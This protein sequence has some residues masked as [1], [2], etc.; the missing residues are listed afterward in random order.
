MDFH[1]PREYDPTLIQ[2]HAERLNFRRSLGLDYCEELESLDDSH[3]TVP[4]ETYVELQA[5]HQRLSEQHAAYKLQQDSARQMER[6]ARTLVLSSLEQYKAQL[7]TLRAKDHLNM[8]LIASLQRQIEDLERKT[9]LKAAVEGALP[10]VNALELISKEVE[11]D[12]RLL[13]VR[14]TLQSAEIR[15]KEEAAEAKLLAEKL[16]KRLIEEKQRADKAVQAA[17]RAI[18]YAKQQTN[19]AVDPSTEP[20]S[21]QMPSKPAKIAPSASKKALNCASIRESLT[22][23]RHFVSAI[24][25][26]M[27]ILLVKQV[28]DALTSNSL[29][30]STLL[31]DLSSKYLQEL[32]ERRRLFNILQE[33]KGNIRV[34]CRVRPS[35]SPQTCISSREDCVLVMTD[36]RTGTMK[37]WEFD[38]VLGP[39][40]TQEEVFACVEPLLQSAVDG[41]NVCIFAYGQTGSGKTYTMEGPSDKP[42]VNYRAAKELF[43]LMES[44]KP[45]WKYQISGSMLEIYNDKVKD[46]LGSGTKLRV[47]HGEAGVDVPEATLVTV[48]DAT[49]V[50]LLLNSGSTQRAI[51]QTN[52]NQHSSRSHLLLNLTIKGEC[53]G[54]QTCSHLHLI[55]LAGSER[56]DKSGSE[57]DR[58]REATHINKSLFAL[59]DVLTA[60]R[61]KQPHVPYRNSTL[62]HLL[63]DSLSGDSKVVMVLQVSP[64]LE[65]WE[66]TGCSLQFGVKARN[67]ELGAARRRTST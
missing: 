15:A 33:L 61:L 2:L 49:E 54:V 29:F 34:L 6:T 20:L 58:L 3:D 1:R 41:Y 23:L 57:G 67:T 16:M 5:K 8:Q 52:M 27:P 14:E 42:G 9:G 45:A 31:Q 38:K 4:L 64:E 22:N 44:R 35:T 46:L 51:G 62:T 28:K 48:N 7:E 32:F 47:R 30:S 24:S 60:K 65:A 18:E 40:S 56:L 10:S 17:K 50:T 26:K 59:G 21:A 53:E 39:A 25:Q 36:Q 11:S 13:E 63:Q 43:S 66:E 55:D 12:F 37:E 19:R